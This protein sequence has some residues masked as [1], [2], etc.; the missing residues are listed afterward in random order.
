[1]TFQKII[2]ELESFLCL[3]ADQNKRQWMETYMRNQFAFFG[4]PAP[5]RKHYQKQWFN[6]HFLTKSDNLT[7]EVIYHLYQLD[8]REFQYVAVDLLAMR[9]HTLTDTKMRDILE[10]CIQKKSWWDTV[11]I[12]AT[13]VAGKWLSSKRELQF[14]VTNDWNR[15][16]NIWLRRSAII[17]QNKYKSKTNF[18]MLRTYILNSAHTNNFFVQKAIGWA[19]REYSKT[20]PSL[21]T[22]FV[23]ANEKILS[24]LAKREAMKWL[25]KKS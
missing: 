18:N 9:A 11:D 13:A 16:D 10:F 17:H 7:L 2:E 4:V 23:L 25:I 24:P 14:M 22:T 15:S 6:R 21:V 19:L 1:M 20:E 12:L 5:I 8:H 3:E